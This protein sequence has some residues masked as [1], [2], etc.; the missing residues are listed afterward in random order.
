MD[1]EEKSLSSRR[2][3]GKGVYDGGAMRRGD[4]EGQVFLLAEI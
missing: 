1:Y 3:K 2:D 4:P